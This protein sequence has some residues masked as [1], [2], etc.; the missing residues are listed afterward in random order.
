MFYFYKTIMNSH[1]QESS[2]LKIC[3]KINAAVFWWKFVKERVD[4][5]F[6]WRNIVFKN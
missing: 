3:K 1:S 4:F 5:E 2:I 6:L